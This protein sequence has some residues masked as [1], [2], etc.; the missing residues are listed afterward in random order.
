MGKSKRKVHKP[1][2]LC[3]YKFMDFEEMIRNTSF[4]YC[5]CPECNKRL[6]DIYDVERKI[7]RANKNGYTNKHCRIISGDLCDA[8]R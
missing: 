2:C 4:G 3:G 8:A 1:M 5:Y 6:Y 7:K